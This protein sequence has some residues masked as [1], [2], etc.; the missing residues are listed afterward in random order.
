MALEQRAALPVPPL[1]QA[2]AAIVLKELAKAVAHEPV[3]LLMLV[4]TLAGSVPVVKAV[5]ARVLKV[6]AILMRLAT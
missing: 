1:A 6:V 3:Q 2:A 5:P 4:G